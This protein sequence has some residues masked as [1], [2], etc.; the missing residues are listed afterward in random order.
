M[1]GALLPLAAELEPGE[2]HV[3]TLDELF[4]YAPYGFS[5]NWTFFGLFDIGFN[6]V[7]LLSMI[8][9]VI[10]AALMLGA[11]R[12]PKIIPGKFQAAMEAFISFVRDNIVLEV[13]GPKGL[14]FVPFLATIFLFIWVNNFFKVT[15]FVIFPTT[16]RMGIPA[17]LAVTALVVF[18]AVGMREQGAGT[19]FKNIMIPPGV[20]WPVLIIL[21]PIE[22]LSTLIVRPFTLA[23]RLFANM[24]AG[25]ILIALS[26][27][28]VNAFLFDVHNIHFDIMTVPLGIVMLGVTPLV[29]AF[30][31]L[32]STLQAYIFTVLTAV[33]IAGAIHPEH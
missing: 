29:F 25:H 26:T 30:E 11:F 19:Y 20:P 4:Q 3:P 14:K 15:P 8:S 31:M 13:I 17:L 1:T 18:V 2:F 33:Y 16:G 27:I 12:N 23:I 10:V 28:A 22:L 9:V 5:E 21:A 24:M 32:V 6:R 7:A